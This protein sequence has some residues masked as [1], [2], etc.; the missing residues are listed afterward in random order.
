MLEMNHTLL[1]SVTWR[2][3]SLVSVF[4]KSHHFL[5]MFLLLMGKRSKRNMGKDIDKSLLYLTD[6]DFLLC[7]AQ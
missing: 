7:I 5:F 4:R 3:S 1:Q 6:L 2:Y